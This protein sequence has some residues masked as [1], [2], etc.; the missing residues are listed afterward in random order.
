MEKSDVIKIIGSLLFFIGG[1]MTVVLFVNLFVENVF[2]LKVLLFV[3]S[4]V[5]WVLLSFYLVGL[6]EVYQKEAQEFRSL[7]NRAEKAITIIEK[8]QGRK[9]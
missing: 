7:G 4:L 6:W 8:L 9:D 5:F 1:V 3:L 2:F